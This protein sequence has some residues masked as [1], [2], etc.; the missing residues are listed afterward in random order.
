MPSDRAPAVW[1]AEAR[2][3]FGWRWERA[4]PLPLHGCAPEDTLVGASAL[5]LHLEQRALASFGVD[6]EL[7]FDAEF[8]AVV[9]VL[10]YQRIAAE[11]AA[12]QDRGGSAAAI[13][14]RF[15]VDHHTAGKA[16]RWYR[17]R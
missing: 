10:V 11:A 15:G 6:A 4:R 3:S 2:S 13:A 17:Q 14:R 9:P 12:M 5:L 1:F 16:I 8:C 7:P